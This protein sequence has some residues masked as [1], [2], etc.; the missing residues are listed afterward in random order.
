MKKTLLFA[1]FAGCFYISPTFAQKP[2]SVPDNATGLCNDGTYYTGKNK[3]GACRGHQGVQTWYGIA[4]AREPATP[5]TAS[6][7]PAPMPGSSSNTTNPAAAQP[8]ATNQ[9]TP[10][11]S[12]AT[13]GMVWA[14]TAKKVYHCPGT[15]WYGK[16]KQGEYMPESDAKAKGFQPNRGRPCAG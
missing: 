16:T 14:N 15:R 13:P 6:S 3:Q 10:A 4:D 8:D 7:A 2:A 5:A 9:A 11:T 1:L 12:P